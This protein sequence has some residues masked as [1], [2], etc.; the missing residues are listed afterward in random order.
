MHP[1]KF[2]VFTIFI[3]VLLLHVS[4]GIYFNGYSPW[5]LPVILLAYLIIII[6]GSIFIRWNFYIRSKNKLPRLRLHF[7]PKG[8]GLSHHEKAVALSFDDG[9]GDHSPTVLDILKK[10]RVP[11]TFFL[12]GRQIEGKEKIVRRMVEEGHE[13]GGHSF[14][15]GRDFDWKSSKEMLSE[16]LSANMAIESIIQKPVRLFRPPYGVT[17]PNLAKAVHQAGMASVGWSIRSLDTIAR[18]EKKLLKRLLRKIKPGAIILLHDHCTI[19]HRILPELIAG[20]R[21]KGYVFETI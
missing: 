20:I 14:S 9:P 21:G 11:A 3:I 8:F 1:S 5:W 17:N 4:A 15:H 10:E 19:T 6:L 12:I 16:I 18:S 7:N 13:I 2:S